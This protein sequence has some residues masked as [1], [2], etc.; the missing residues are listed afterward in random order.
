MVRTTNRQLT[1]LF[2]LLVLLMA[3]FGGWYADG[4]WRIDL[5]TLNAQTVGENIDWIDVVSTLGEQVIQ[6]FLG[7]TSAG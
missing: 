1:R 3:L 7:L 2:F 5:S 4:H 6:L